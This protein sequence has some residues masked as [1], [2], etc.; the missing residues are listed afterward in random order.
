MNPSNR[1]AILIAR[2]EMGIATSL[3]KYELFLIRN[4]LIK[5]REKKE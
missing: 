5:K 4:G 2:T 3:E 1:L